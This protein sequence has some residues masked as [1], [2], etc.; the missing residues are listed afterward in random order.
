MEFLTVLKSGPL[1]FWLN[2]LTKQ[3]LSDALMDEYS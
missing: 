3:E 1:G 2:Q